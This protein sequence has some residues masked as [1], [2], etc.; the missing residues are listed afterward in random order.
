[1]ARK[2]KKMA[3]YEVIGK[4]HLKSEPG[5]GLDPLHP[6]KVGE[7]SSGPAASPGQQPQSLVTRWPGKPK[8]LQLNAGRVELSIPYAV[9]IAILMAG[10]L[11]VLVVF[12]FGQNNPLVS[13]AAVHTGSI[14]EPVRFETPSPGRTSLERHSADRVLQKG[15]NRIVIKQYN[16]ARDLQPV[17]RYF[18]TYGIITEI[19]KRRS[20]Y[21]LV[22]ADTYENP[23]K[24]GTDGYAAKE[25]IAQIG[26]G[27]QAPP[28]YETFA[29]K[30]FTDA[31]GE[32]IK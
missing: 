24:P 8:V 13:D 22:T 26:A 28:S 3:L 6:E 14:S 21:F 16:T 10:L 7:H 20:G 19:E 29:P 30:M 11:L 2:P 12:R 17:Q 23:Q 31:Y 1:M 18:A 4:T 15:N 32:K 25:K 27:Y 5:G 9:A